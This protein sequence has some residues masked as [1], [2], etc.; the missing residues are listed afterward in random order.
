[1]NIENLKINLNQYFN[2]IK[3]VFLRDYSKYMN[4]EKIKKISELNDIF[5]IDDESKFKI[6]VSDKINICLNI[7]DFIDDNRLNNDADLKDISID[8]RIYVKFLIDNKNDIE[9]LILSIILKPI[10]TYLVGKNDNVIYMGIID[11]IVNNF[12]SKYNITYKK[13]Y[14]SKELEIIEILK[15]IT[16]ET[17]IYKAVLNNDISI[18]ESAY[19]LVADESNEEFNELYKS[20]NNEYQIYTKRIGKVY[21]SDTLYDYQSIS[22]K[23]EKDVLNKIIENKFKKDDTKRDRFLSIKKCIENLKKHLIIFGNEERLLLDN[24]EIEINNLINQIGIN[25]DNLDNY[26]LRALDIENKLMPLTEKVWIKQLTHPVS[27][28]EGSQFCFLIGD[29][30]NQT[31]TESKLITDK[32]LKNVNNKLK[33]NYGFIYKMSDNIIYSSS[34]DILVKE[35][36]SETTS[37]NL[38]DY[39]GIKIEI[40]N[41]KDSKLLTPEVLMREDIKN[42]DSGKVLLYNPSVIGIFVIYDN[43]FNPDYKKALELSE[44]MELP[45]V[46]INRNLYQVKEEQKKEIEIKEPIRKQKQ[47]IEKK[48]KISEKLKLF[49]NNILYD[50]EELEEFKK[51]I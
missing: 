20:L 26:Y 47:H 33:Y 25:E 49:K 5:K 30:N 7:E 4:E 6:Y 48:T 2:Y 40:D 10:I 32:H 37:D 23:K 42:R 50:E 38:I 16:G 27:Y 41:Q 17:V 1:M 19:D 14:E 34:K 12:E 29:K 24:S 3:T 13:P 11:A 35:V 31:I 43:E 8:G 36:S 46:K 15:N 45:L 51:A 44:N 9:R 18:L 21:Y 39:N 22:Y 28:Q